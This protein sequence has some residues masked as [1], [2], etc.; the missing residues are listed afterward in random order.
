MRRCRH[1]QGVFLVPS[2][3]ICSPFIL[4][5][6]CKQQ[7][8]N[9]SAV[10][11]GS[12][13]ALAV[14]IP[15]LP[16][17]HTCWVKILR[18][19]NE[20]W[21]GLWT[22]HSSMSQDSKLWQEELPSTQGGSAALLFTQCQG[23]SGTLAQCELRSS[24]GRLCSTNLASPAGVSCARP[25]SCVPWSFQCN[26]VKPSS[27][28]AQLGRMGRESCQL[29]GWEPRATKPALTFCV[30]A[31]QRKSRLRLESVKFCRVILSE[32]LTG[33][34]E[35]V[36]DY[37]LPAKKSNLFSVLSCTFMLVIK[38]YCITGK[39]EQVSMG[40]TFIFLHHQTSFIC[41]TDPAIIS[42]FGIFNQ[43]WMTFQKKYFFCQ[44]RQI[45]CSDN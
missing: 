8:T 41:S 26:G 25:L 3:V 10:K 20:A 44:T 29:H 43:V 23:H 39:P 27:W 35:R 16:P 24:C 6:L 12:D 30:F 42:C 15:S 45:Q 34:A 33:T 19:S 17:N 7:H 38:M 18:G 14:M 32:P 1:F 2:C 13:L 9:V 5:L 22:S 31:I 36:K 21:G 11:L 40:V 37:Q 28:G 4:H